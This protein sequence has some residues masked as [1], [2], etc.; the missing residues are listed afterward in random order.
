M[1]TVTLEVDVPAEVGRVLCEAARSR[2]ESVSDWLAQIAV[3]ALT[4]DE[5]AEYKRAWAE[6]ALASY[7]AERGEITSAEVEAVKSA[8]QA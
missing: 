1:E 5:Q 4:A 2:G 7:E 8:W 3:G 6:A